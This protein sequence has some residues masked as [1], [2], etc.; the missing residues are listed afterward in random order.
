MILILMSFFYALRKK[1]LNFFDKQD[2]EKG[3]VYKRE[4]D[5]ANK[6]FKYLFFSSFF[7][8]YCK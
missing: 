4:I 7:L 8:N 3:F 2:L 1:K 6:K 5:K